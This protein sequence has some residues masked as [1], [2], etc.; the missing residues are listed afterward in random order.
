[1]IANEDVRVSNLLA[2]RAEMHVHDLAVQD[3]FDI[4]NALAVGPSTNALVS[5]DV[6]WDGV[7]RT[8]NVSDAANGFRGTFVENQATVTWSGMNELGFRFFWDPG[9]FSTSV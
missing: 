6:V 4:P 8:V 7:T 1:A 3:Y 5:F 2:G 9:T